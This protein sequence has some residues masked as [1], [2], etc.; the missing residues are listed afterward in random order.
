[1]FTRRRSYAFVE[2]VLFL[3]ATVRVAC[4]ACV[5]AQ[6]KVTANHIT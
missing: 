5:S 3:A 6:Y 1:M 4:L 2:Q